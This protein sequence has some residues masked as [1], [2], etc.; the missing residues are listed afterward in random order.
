[1][2]EDWVQLVEE[3]TLEV[4]EMVAETARLVVLEWLSLADCLQVYA[5]L[6]RRRD[7]ERLQN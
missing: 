3:G 2:L 1:M 5:D 7:Q 6:V 4:E